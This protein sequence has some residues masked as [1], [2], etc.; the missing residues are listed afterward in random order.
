[1]KI[2]VECD[3]PA[4][5]RMEPIGD[6]CEVHWKA[7]CDINREWQNRPIRDE[8]DSTGEAL[9]IAFHGAEDDDIED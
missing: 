7:A 5:H 8:H 1:M 4:T 9:R 3:Q 2:C 6:L